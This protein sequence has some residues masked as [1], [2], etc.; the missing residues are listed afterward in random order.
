LGRHGYDLFLV[1]RNKQR[2]DD[3]GHEIG[4]RNKVSATT[5]AIDLAVP[6]S[7]RQV[8]DELQSRGTS[9]H[10][11]VNNA[12]F[13]VFGPFHLTDL[14]SNVA[15]LHTNIVALTH[16]TRL[17]LPSMVKRGSGRLLNVAST[18]AFQPGP[19][20]AT[21]YASKAYVVSFSGAI[22]NELK[23]TGV[24][25]T[26]LC[27]G[28]TETEF[29]A[30]AGMMNSRLLIPPRMSAATVARIGYIGTVRG[31]RLV[32]PGLH[33]WLLAEAVRFAPRRAVTQVARIF[34]EKRG[35][36]RKQ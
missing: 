7:P 1:A 19:L 6:D 4:T 15:L 36:R 22:A 20:M 18:A 24:T 12:A 33:N 2:L 25:V 34:Q 3:L 21:Y 5:I 26:C 9:I 30:R 27:P 11:L 29:H 13:G 17:F 14:E 28:P 10:V 16:L 23:G 8:F 32:I 31:K 35:A